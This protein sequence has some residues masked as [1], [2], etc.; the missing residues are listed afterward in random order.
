MRIATAL[1]GL[2]MTEVDG[3]WSRFAGSAAVIVG[4]YCG[5]VITVPYMGFP[6]PVSNGMEKRPPGFGRA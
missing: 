3:G 6:S 5:T 2:A 1:T 4:V